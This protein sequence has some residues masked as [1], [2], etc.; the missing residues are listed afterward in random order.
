MKIVVISDTHIPASAEDLPEKIKEQIKDC[1]CVVHAGDAT[2]MKVIN[3]LRLQAITHAVC[4]NMD[5]PEV[6]KALPETLLFEAD[7]KVIGVVH[8][9]G[10][11]YAARQTAKKS[12]KG[13]KP[14]VIIFGHT[15]IPF[16]EMI[17]KILFLNPGSVSDRM[18]APYR[19]FGI[20]DIS[21]GSIKAEIIRLD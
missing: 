8:G 18:F 19:S 11:S 4:G 21:P 2:E 17:D 16:N 13:K 1:D 14:D 15:H 3:E 7:G 10:P 9:Y 6:K 12:F 20:I 5:S